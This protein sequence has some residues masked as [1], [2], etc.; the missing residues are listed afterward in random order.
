MVSVHIGCRFDHRDLFVGKTIIVIAHKQMRL[1]KVLIR[2]Y[3]YL[4]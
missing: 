2:K 4:N 1:L 3:T